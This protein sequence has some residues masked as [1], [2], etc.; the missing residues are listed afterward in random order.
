M[1]DGNFVIK[2]PRGRIDSSIFQ[3]SGTSST[4]H[5]TSYS[6]GTALPLSGIA[7]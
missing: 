4:T 6:K 1:K 3:E 5:Q 7:G 2:L